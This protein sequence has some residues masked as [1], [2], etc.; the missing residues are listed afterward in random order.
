MIG[1]PSRPTRELAWSVLLGAAVGAAA[2]WLPGME[3]VGPAA[4]GVLGLAAG[5]VGGA[6]AGLLAV[7][8]GVGGMIAARPEA[9]AVALAGSLVGGAV[10]AALGALAGRQAERTAPELAIFD[11]IP[12]V[13]VLYDPPTLRIEHANASAIAHFGYSA[14]EFRGMP[15]TRLIP[16]ED[17]PRMRNYLEA[18]AEK[19]IR[20]IRWTVRRADGTE[21]E[22]EVISTAVRMRGRALRLVIGVD[23]SNYLKLGARLRRAT[24]E[25]REAKAQFLAVVGHELRTPLTAVAGAAQALEAEPLTRSQRQLVETIRRNANLEARLVDDMLDFIRSE[26][27]ALRLDARAIDV[28][29]EIRAA[30]E[31]C[32]REIAR[33]RQRL[34]LE[35]SADPPFAHA[36]PARLQQV[37]LNLLRNANKFTPAEG[38]IRVVTY[39]TEPEA[40][41]AGPAE[42]GSDHSTD[43]APIP[44]VPVPG[45]EQEPPER[46]SSADPRT[47]APTLGTLVVEV[48]DTGAGIDPAELDRIF[49]PFA[50]GHTTRRLWSEGLG[51]GLA[52]SRSIAV[53]HGGR[54]TAQSEGAGRGSTFRLEL[55]RAAAPEPAAG[56]KP[57]PAAGPLRPLEILLVDDS[58]DIRYS[59]SRLLRQQDHRV[60][61]AGDVASALAALRSRRFDLLISDLE[62]PDG[63]GHDLLHAA[64]NG[65]APAAPPAIALSGYDAPNDRLRSREAG[66]ALHLAKPVV[67]ERLD[68]AIR[69]ALNGA[70]G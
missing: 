43:S 24:H 69:T 12:L 16:P 38:V 60:T 30:V 53:A 59:L 41:V 13:A 25:A 44:L 31:S 22:F 20:Q 8:G 57:T 37:L 33:R 27:R 70:S 49:D 67:G 65:H 15:L 18:T 14:A 17:V 42:P 51:L 35:L 62:L 58:Q 5:R 7:V 61:V 55:V 26:R 34:E 6:T 29:E 40:V 66:F 56:G 47:P 64:R 11:A 32:G 54:L 2:S 63:T 21:G 1:V 3:W 46:R 9:P 52:I 4:L 28:H 36:D 23:L 10:G 50:Q 68:E 45:A 48:S 39:L 19:A